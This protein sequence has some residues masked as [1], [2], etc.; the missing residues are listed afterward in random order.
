MQVSG[1]VHDLAALSPGTQPPAPIVYQ[2][3][4]PQSWSLEAVEKKG[5]LLPLPEVQPH[6][7]G[8]PTLTL[9]ATPTY[10]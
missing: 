9:V 10:L 3:G 8:S 6:I 1:E 2:A 7:L 5:T 4:W